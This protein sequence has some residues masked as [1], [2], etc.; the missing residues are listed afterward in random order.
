MRYFVEENNTEKEE[1]YVK[2][3]FKNPA[4]TGRRSDG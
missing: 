2:S 4:F 1:I 3:I